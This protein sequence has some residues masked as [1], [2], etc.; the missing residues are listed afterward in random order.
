M[1][2]QNRIYAVFRRAEQASTRS[3]CRRTAK[4]N[5]KLYAN[6]GRAAKK[7]PL[8][9]TAAKVHIDGLT[10]Y[11]EYIITVEN[12]SGQVSKERLV[13]TG[14]VFGTAVN[15][16]H[17]DDKA[18]AFSV[19]ACAAV[20]RQIKKRNAFG[21]NRHFK[22]GFPQNLTLIYR[23]DDDGEAGATSRN[24]CRSSGANCLNITVY[25]ICWQC[26]RN[27]GDILIGRSYDEG[28]N[29]ENPSVIARGSCFAGNGFHRAP[30]YLKRQTEDCGFQLNTEAG[31]LRRTLKRR[32]IR[33]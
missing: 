7:L 33:R 11:C 17:P 2:L 4:P 29:W 21:V 10:P 3:G 8:K 1:R 23:S 16:L 31:S 32:Y 15:Y 14:E 13:R 19:I 18:Y 12:N 24:Y 9:Q 26:Q 6:S 22:N 30:A 5:T 27:T 25:Y 28:R 20:H